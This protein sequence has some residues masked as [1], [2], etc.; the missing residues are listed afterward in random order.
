M[1]LAVNPNTGLDYVVKVPALSPS[2][3][4]AVE[5]VGWGMGGKALVA[6]WALAGLGEEVVAL[7]FAGGWVG[8]HVAR[9]LTS[10]G[11]VCEFVWVESE[12]RLNVVLVREPG[13]RETTLAAPGIVVSKD[14]VQ[15]LIDTFHKWLPQARAVILGGSLPVGCPLSLFYEL[16]LSARGLGIP[17]VVDSSGEVLRLAVNAHPTAI[18][19]NRFEAQELAGVPITEVHMAKEV[20]TKLFQQGIR[21]VVITLDQ[22]GLVAVGDGAAWFAHAPEMKP[23]STTGAGDAVT[24]GLAWGLVHKVSIKE[25][26]QMG[27]A[28]AWASMQCLG[29]TKIQ[30]TDVHQR[31]QTVV[32]EKL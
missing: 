23:R 14:D 18:K 31:A 20:A 25:A 21:W 12:S 24:A 7:G 16:V 9:L 13:A 4:V 26:V 22:Q 6:A 8:H 2:G 32:V 1:I 5:E 28:L 3:R 27:V 15:Q 11:I 17:V 19:P 29:T 30:F 10:R